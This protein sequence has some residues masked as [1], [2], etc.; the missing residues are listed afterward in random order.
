MY[1]RFTQD[2]LA[3]IYFF[4]IDNNQIYEMVNI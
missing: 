3:Y 1:K 2:I 4:L